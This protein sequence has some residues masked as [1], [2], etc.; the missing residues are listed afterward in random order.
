MITENMIYWITR[1]D[2][3]NGLAAFFI[4]LSLIGIVV[5]L[6]FILNFPDDGETRICK[7]VIGVCSSIFLVMVLVLT[8]LP[9]TKEMC[10]IKVIPAIANNEKINDIS[11][12]MLDSAKEWIKQSL[13]AKGDLKKS[14]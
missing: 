5:T 10:A 7:W 3:L 14:E 1:F 9:T 11:N 8:F 6:P 12:F 13:P 4:A 2:A